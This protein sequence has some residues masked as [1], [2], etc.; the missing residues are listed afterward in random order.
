MG[1][2]VGEGVFGAAVGDAVGEGEGLAVGGA[3]GKV[4]KGVGRGVG[5]CPISLTMLTLTAQLEHALLCM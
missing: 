1:V 4:G 5:V 2:L 3:V